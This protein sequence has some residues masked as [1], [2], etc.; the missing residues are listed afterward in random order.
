MNK[1][2]PVLFV[3]PVL[4]A[5]CLSDKKEEPVDPAALYFDYKISAGEGNDNLTIL[6]QFRLGDPEGEAVSIDNM[7]SVTLDGET[8]EVDSTPRTGV[9]YELHKPIADFT[10]KHAIVF[11]RDGHGEIR[12]S[13]EFDPLVILSAWPDTVRRDGFVI[14]LGGLEDPAVLRVLMIDTSAVNDGVN[15]LDTLESDQLIIP[16]QY[17]ETL[18]PGP[19]QLELIRESARE[20]DSQ[21]R[22]GG[23]LLISYSLRR[24]LHLAD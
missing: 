22:L 3:L 5:A 20:L 23:R 1:A 12:D 14:D 13:F 8:P 6:F 21:S 18:A 7:G 16:G 17:L 4:V 24:E 9:F 2:I 15:E 10:G 19:V 11:K